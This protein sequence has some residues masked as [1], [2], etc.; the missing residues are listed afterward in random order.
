MKYKRRGYERKKEALLKEFKLKQASVKSMGLGKS[1]SNL[2]RYRQ[3]AKARL[4][5]RDFN[6]VISIDEKNRM[7]DV[8]GMTTYEELV[9]KT[10]EYGLMPCVVPQL[11]SITIGGAV[12]GIGIE[13][14]SFKYGLVHE[15]VTEMEV[16][17]GDG[18][19]VTCTPNNSH[20][21]LFFGFPNSYGT[22][23]YAL[24]LVIKLVPVKKYVKLVH[25]QFSNSEQYF[26]KI[27]ALCK[28]KKI[29]FIDGT[30]FNDE[31][32]YIT[33][34]QF[35]NEAPF[36]SNYKFMKIYYKSIQNKSVDYLSTSDY[37]W[38]WDTDWFWCSKHF[39]VQNPLFRFLVGPWFLKSSV[40]WKIR[41]FNSKYGITRTVEHL[42][43]K[44]RTESVVQDVQIPIKKSQEFIEFFH[45]KIGLQPIWVCPVKKHNSKRKYPLYETKPILYLNFGFWDTKPT[46]HKD[47]HY[48][49]SIEKKV[50][51]LQGRKMLYSRSFYSPKEFAQLYDQKAHHSLKRKYDPQGV[52]GDFYEKCVMNK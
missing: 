11:K 25:L 38:R 6:E 33:V 22:L 15:T 19:I 23:G 26:N 8:E 10:L 34:G 50:E 4:N 16:L 49:K 1:T 37:I 36:V 43:G 52:F 18:K 46:K 14:S 39:G 31:E 44:G 29:D 2:F 17:T 45:E 21:D 32:M 47:G 40:Y 27:S 30:I 13:A 20:K 7:A 12:T 24:R 41:Y 48:T 5:V 42:L 28:D 9:R 51:K 3:K 35:V